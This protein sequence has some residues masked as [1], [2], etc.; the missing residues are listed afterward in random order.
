MKKILLSTKQAAK[1]L[2]VS[3]QTIINWI[4]GGVFKTAIKLNPLKRNSPLRIDAIEVKLV[5][6][7]QVYRVEEHQTHGP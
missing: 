7:G 2:G 6:K 5:K 1:V 4:R 3:D